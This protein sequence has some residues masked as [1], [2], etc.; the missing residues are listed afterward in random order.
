MPLTRAGAAWVG[1]SVAALMAILLIIFLVQNTHRV[2]VEFLWMSTGTSLALML[3]IAAVSAAL[4][5]V[6]LGTARIV[7]LRKMVRSDTPVRKR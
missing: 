1:V 6:I 4:I 3:L 5:T 7:Q 2:E